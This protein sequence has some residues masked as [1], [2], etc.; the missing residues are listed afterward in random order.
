[1][2]VDELLVVGWGGRG[3]D[4]VMLRHIASCNTYGQRAPTITTQDAA[5]FRPPGLGVR[6]DRPVVSRRWG[7]DRQK[8]A[9][10]DYWRSEAAKQI[11]KSRGYYGRE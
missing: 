7:D 4:R 3:S 11:E 10:G 5:I 2:Y 1:M 9:L 6:L 8:R